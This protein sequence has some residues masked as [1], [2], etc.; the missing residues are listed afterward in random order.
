M[1]KN[2]KK[3][4][5]SNWIQCSISF[6]IL[7]TL[8]FTTI[9]VCDQL[10]FNKKSLRP[11]IF[12]ELTEEV[13]ITQEKI[14]NIVSLSNIGK[15]PALNIYLDGFLAQYMEFPKDTIKK[16]ISN[17]EFIPKA[18]IFPNEQKINIEVITIPEIVN[19]KQKREIPIDS[20]RNLLKE[21]TY[22]HFYLTYE[23]E[24]GTKYYLRETNE[25]IYK[26]DTKEG[27]KVGW[28]FIKSSLEP[29]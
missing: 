5:M 13:L 17:F 27:I 8:I 21:K 4:S 24:S 18:I 22:L 3:L 28:K 14:S 23:S 20:I 26:N 15:T 9:N 6:F 2:I 12:P 19:I 25:L 10:N 16:R 7:G 11:W 29:L 1:N